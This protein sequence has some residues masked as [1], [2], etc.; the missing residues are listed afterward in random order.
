[1]WCNCCSVCSVCSRGGAVLRA[2]ALAEHQPTDA[3]VRAPCC[4]TC[5]RS[6][7]RLMVADPTDSLLYSSRGPRSASSAASTSA[8]SASDR[9]TRGERCTGRRVSAAGKQVRQGLSY[10]GRRG[11]G[12]GSH[13]QHKHTTPRT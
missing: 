11:G 9:G 13:A 3:G 5:T 10:A 6:P 4:G 2:G 7:S 8:F 1:M 12:G